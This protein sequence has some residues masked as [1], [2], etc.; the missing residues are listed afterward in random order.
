MAGAIGNCAAARGD[1][2]VSVAE[3]LRGVSAKQAGS[4]AKRDRTNSGDR[5]ERS[6][7]S[8]VSDRASTPAKR[9]PIARTAY[10]NAGTKVC[11][12]PDGSTCAVRAALGDFAATA[13]PFKSAQAGKNTR[14]SVS[15]AMA[16]AANATMPSATAI[17]TA[18]STAANPPTASDAAKNAIAAAYAGGSARTIAASAADSGASANRNRNANRFKRGRRRASDLRETVL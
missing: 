10:E 2:P 4:A 1:R 3:N 18:I 5:G 17:A 12:A 7:H 16:I 14:A 15:A 13:T 9:A 8:S 11:A 6:D